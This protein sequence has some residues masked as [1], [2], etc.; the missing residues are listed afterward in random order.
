MK[1][2]VVNS[3]NMLRDFIDFPRKIYPDT[4]LLDYRI[5]SSAAMIHNIDSFSY[6][7]VYH[8][9]EIVGRFAVGSNE[10]IQDEN[11]NVIGQI[12]LVETVND[13]TVFSYIMK[14]AMQLLR[15]HDTILYPFFFS[16][17]HQYRLCVQK[18]M[19]IFWDQP[20]LSYYAE[21]LQRLG[22]AGKFI[23][24][25]S[26]CDD[27]PSVLNTTRKH[28]ETARSHGISFRHL[29]IAD[30]DGE[31]KL[32]NDLS[33]QGFKDNRFYCPLSFSEFSLL[34]RK[35][36]KIVDPEFIIIAEDSRQNPV[37][38]LFSLPDYT[39]L[40]QSL[41]LNSFWGRV[42]FFLQKKR[43]PDGLLVKSGAVVPSA[44]NKSIFSAMLYLQASLAVKRH[45]TYLINAYY[46]E[47]N[48]CSNY[49]ADIAEENIYELY[50]LK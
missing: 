43:K 33:L 28:Y 45:F 29:K 27:L 39:K 31:L 46:S 10:L 26:K 4:A 24:K 23:Y 42:Q 19:E 5:K 2:S 48:Y 50:Q 25:S 6:V 13:F 38:F 9:R 47:A 21:F 30:I 8:E 17:W 16:T 35:V 1:H 49:L 3:S 37:G 41:N 12:A 40:L 34:Y 20:Y 44:R 18:E 15:G 11:K 32:L 14:T 7:I 22:F 36:V